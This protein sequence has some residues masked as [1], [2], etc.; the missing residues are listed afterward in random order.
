R[1]RR[2]G[3]AGGVRDPESAPR[4]LRPRLVGARV[5]SE[6][7]ATP[8]VWCPQVL[9][10]RRYGF[11]IPTK[12]PR[13]SGVSSLGSLPIQIQSSL[14]FA[15]GGGAWPRA[16][17]TVATMPRPGSTAIFKKPSWR[18]RT[19]GALAAKLTGKPRR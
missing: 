10:A 15:S 9:I 8:S 1:R 6:L 5:H 14:S 4:G 2:G 13:G 7:D 3:P 19:Q 17:S 11:L 12:V 18:V 16:P